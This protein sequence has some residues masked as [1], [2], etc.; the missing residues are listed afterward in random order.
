MQPQEN[1]TETTRQGSPLSVVDNA[2]GDTGT[3]IEERFDLVDI[4]ES[5]EK[6]KAVIEAVTDEEVQAL[7]LNA[8]TVVGNAFRVARSFLK[9]KELFSKYLQKDIF[10]PAKYEDLPDAAKAFLYACF[11]LKQAQSGNAELRALLEE[12]RPLQTKLL[13]AA[14][15]LWGNDP[16]LGGVIAGIRSGRSRKDMAHDIGNMAALFE[17]Q[18]ER[19]KNRCEISEDDI[20][21]AHRVSLRLIELLRSDCSETETAKW[22]SLREKAGTYLKRSVEEIRRAAGFMF[23]NHPT[24]MERYPSLYAGR[25]TNRPSRS[26]PAE[27]SATLPQPTNASA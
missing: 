16:V 3:R 25:R 12:A 13:K 23:K 17:E 26:H 19:V 21:K 5:F 7:P 24:E 14:V 18:W 22:R 6:Q 4:S 20:E 10:D 11:K 27:P 2:N 9:D 8:V 15:Y 1:A